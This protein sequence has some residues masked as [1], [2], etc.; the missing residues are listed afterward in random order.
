MSAY[1]C[2]KDI[3]AVHG[4]RG[5]REVHGVTRRS[6]DEGALHCPRIVYAGRGLCASETTSRDRDSHYLPRVRAT[7]LTL[8][9][10]FGRSLAQDEFAQ[11]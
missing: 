6:G 1:L 11:G 3:G 5:A 7:M 9:E 10:K 8:R 4:P 2:A